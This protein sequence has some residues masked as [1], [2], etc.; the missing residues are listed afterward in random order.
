MTPRLAPVI[1]GIFTVGGDE[2]AD[3]GTD[4]LGTEP[5]ARHVGHIKRAHFLQHLV[6]LGFA[7]TWR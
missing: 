4:Q 5:Q 7:S 1:L 2:E 3:R 6:N